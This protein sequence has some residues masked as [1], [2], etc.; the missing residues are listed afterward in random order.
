ME[1]ADKLLFYHRGSDHESLG[2]IL[3]IL[4]GI[5]QPHQPP[6]THTHIDTHGCIVRPL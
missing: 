3:G 5:L 2:G 4:G 1:T 6:F